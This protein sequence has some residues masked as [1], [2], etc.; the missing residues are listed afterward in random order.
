MVLTQSEAKSDV[1]P[2]TFKL[3]VD[4]KSFNVPSRM[5]VRINQLVVVDKHHKTEQI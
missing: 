2:E 5:S 3:Q 1:A 4:L